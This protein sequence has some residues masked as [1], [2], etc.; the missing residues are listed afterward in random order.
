M[1]GHDGNAPSTSDTVVGVHDNF[2]R[3][4]LF[5]ALGACLCSLFFD[6]KCEGERK[7]SV[8]TGRGF[9]ISVG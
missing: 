4:E 9:I 8:M 1:K 3:L 5:G 6:R 7:N 2:V